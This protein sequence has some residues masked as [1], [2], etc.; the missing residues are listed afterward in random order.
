MTARYGMRTNCTKNIENM[1]HLGYNCTIVL[2]MWRRLKSEKYGIIAFCHYFHAF[3]Q[4][5][6]P[7][8]RN[9]FIVLPIRVIFVSCRK[10]G[11]DQIILIIK[12]GQKCERISYLL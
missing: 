6:F 10:N 7:Y 9:Y 12:E 5:I 2:R 4:L 11:Q 3:R 1:T 8:A